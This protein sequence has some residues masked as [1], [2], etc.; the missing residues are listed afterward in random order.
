[1]RARLQQLGVPCDLITVDNGGHGMGSWDKLPSQ[2]WKPRLV[3]WL[4][5]NLK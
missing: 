3:E 4:R 5:A 2:D 1:M